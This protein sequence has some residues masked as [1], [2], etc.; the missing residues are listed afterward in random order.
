M[1]KK[2]LLFSSLI[3]LSSQISQCQWECCVEETASEAEDNVRVPQVPSPTKEVDRCDSYYNC[4]S[5]ADHL[6]SN[7]NVKECFAQ[8]IRIF[9]MLS[10]DLGINNQVVI[11]AFDNHL[12]QGNPVSSNR[13]TN[14]DASYAGANQEIYLALAAG[15]YYLRAYID[16]DSSPALP[17]QYGEMEVVSEKPFGVFGA[18]SNATKIYVP[19]DSRNQELSIYLN[20]LFQ[21]PE[22][23]VPSN[24]YLRVSI[25]S[26]Q[27]ETIPTG[28][29]I[30]IELHNT[31]DFAYQP[32][33]QFTLPS[34]SLKVSGNMDYTEYVSNQLTT[35]DYFVFA[36]ID[37]NGNG[38]Y[39]SNEPSQTFR[40]YGV[41]ATVAIIAN[42]TE[43]ISLVLGVNN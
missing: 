41:E 7:C 6:T 25:D 43:S 38:Y 26:S 42:R 16:T 5:Q 33:Y 21:E 4:D 39:D 31:I 12:F 29:D 14:F 20:E 1:L 27:I 30:Y 36:Y 24:A 10:E 19:Y 11:E 37:S 17:Y 2:I 28:Q 15:E 34:E 18:L 35:G 23:P 8:K 22:A 9:Y 32:V 3:L 13:I 40:R